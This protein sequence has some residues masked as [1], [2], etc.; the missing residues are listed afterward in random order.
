MVLGDAES[1]KRVLTAFAAHDAVMGY[2]Q[3]MN[4]LAAF[5]LLAGVKE[6]DAF[7]SAPDYLLYV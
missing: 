4:F 5:L 6:E 1:L 2:V 7:W 3:S